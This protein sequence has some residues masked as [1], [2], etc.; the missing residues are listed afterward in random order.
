MRGLIVLADLWRMKAMSSIAVC[1]PLP[2]FLLCFLLFVFLSIVDCLSSKAQWPLLEALTR[3][4]E[5]GTSYR[6]N[7]ALMFLTIY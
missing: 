7:H 1:F 2:F 3:R 6:Q 5:L 4:R